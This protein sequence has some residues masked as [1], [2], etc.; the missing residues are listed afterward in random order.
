MM[1]SL[2]SQRKTVQTSW[3]RICTDKHG[4]MTTTYSPTFGQARNLYLFIKGFN[5]TLYSLQAISRRVVKWAEETSTYSWSRFC[6]V[7]C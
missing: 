7:N 6:T 3:S 1:H 5:F 2:W 4:E